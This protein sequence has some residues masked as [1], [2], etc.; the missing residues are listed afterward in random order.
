MRQL[1]ALRA[2]A[3]SAVVIH[4]SLPDGWGFGADFGVKLFFTL[5]GF[6]IT[7]LLLRGRDA[8]DQHRELLRQA[9]GRFYARRFLR[10]FP[11]YYGVIAVAL[12]LGLPA[13]RQILWWLLSYTINIHMAQQGWFEAGFAHFW[14]LAVEEQFYVVWPWVIFLAPR[15]ALPACVAVLTLL[16]PAY[17]L[18][19]VLSGYMNMTALS[20]YISTWACLDS[21]GWGAM[22]AL[23]ARTLPSPVLDRVLLRWILPIAVA[24]CAAARWPGAGPAPEIVMYPFA[25]AAVCCAIVRIAARGV[26][27]AGRF[28]LDARP[29]LEIGKVSYGVYVYHPFVL[30][31][32]AWAVGRLHWPATRAA[33]LS[34]IAAVP[35]T[36][37]VAMASWRLFERPLNDLKE[38]FRDP[39]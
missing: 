3:V 30:A 13:T 24:L 34:G 7:G 20:A 27:G 14:S 35:A 31:L 6:L 12:L 11:L 5:S 26:T 21:L 23:L 36:L 1:D 39:A 28:M 38:R 4:H 33:W 32:C 18:S 22:L 15:R 17:R 25:Q 10:I 9:V 29:A 19:Y 16:A 37:V 8:V 2:Y